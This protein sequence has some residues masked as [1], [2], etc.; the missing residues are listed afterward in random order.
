[1]ACPFLDQGQPECQEKLCLDQLVHVLGVC[2][3]EQFER[4]PIFV[5][6]RE[7]AHRVPIAVERLSRCA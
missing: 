6:I 3:H 1:M 7:Y 5:R 4:C 2:G